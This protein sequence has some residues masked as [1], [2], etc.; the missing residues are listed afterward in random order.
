[1]YDRYADIGK[2]ITDPDK[3]QITGRSEV[4]ISSEENYNIVIDLQGH[5]EEFEQMRPFIAFI[6]Q[7]VCRL[8]NIAQKFDSL[9]NRSGQ[10]PYLVAVIFIDGSDVILRYW[11]TEENTQFD[12]VFAHDEG[13]F[14]LKSF[15][16]IRQISP[17]W[18]KALSTGHRRKEQGQK[19]GFLR[20]KFSTR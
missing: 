2:F 16:T 12:V 6:A 10:F 5:A 18:E 17:E 13:E 11:G 1:M 7:N 8:D 19:K 20:W 3:L 14:T 4:S 15:G 9:H